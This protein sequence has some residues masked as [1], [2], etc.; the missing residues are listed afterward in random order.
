[1]VMADDGESWISVTSERDDDFCIVVEK[2]VW[3]ICA[4][5]TVKLT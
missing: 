3:D 5:C 4:E 1:M 2:G